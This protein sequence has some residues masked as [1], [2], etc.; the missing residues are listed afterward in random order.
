MTSEESGHSRPFKVLQAHNYHV[1]RGGSEVMFESTI[2][3]LR[4]HRH[5]VTVLRRD[6][7]RIST[8]RDKLSAFRECLHS[9][10]ARA[11]VARIV[12]DMRPDVAH[13]HNL[14]PLLSPSAR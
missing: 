2:E 13:F 7:Q 14:Y 10:T 6:N 11:D 5:E 1:D 8:F 3:V 12:R 4:A 9:R